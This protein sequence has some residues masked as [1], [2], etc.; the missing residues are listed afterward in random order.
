M[1]CE[2][3]HLHAAIGWFAGIVLHISGVVNFFGAGAVVGAAEHDSLGGFWRTSWLFYQGAGF[4]KLW[5][6][7]LWTL[8]DFADCGGLQFF[9]Q[10]VICAFKFCQLLGILADIGSLDWLMKL[11]DRLRGQGTIFNG[12]GMFGSRKIKGRSWLNAMFGRCHPW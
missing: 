3:V 12:F 2:V 10:K 6:F 4:L 1:R 9:T 11:R 8:E 7:L 5:G